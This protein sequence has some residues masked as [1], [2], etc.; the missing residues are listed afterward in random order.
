MEELRGHT[1]EIWALALSPDGK[2][3]AS[4]GKDRRIGVWNTETN[5]WVKGFGGHRDS[6]SVSLLSLDYVFQR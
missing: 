3:L 2:L 1:D 5:E 4:G 6:I